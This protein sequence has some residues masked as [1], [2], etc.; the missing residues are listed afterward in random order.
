M[1]KAYDVQKQLVQNFKEC[2]SNTKQRNS[3]GINGKSDVINNVIALFTEKEMVYNGFKIGI[4]PLPS[5]QIAVAL[6]KSISSEHSSNLNEYNSL[7]EKTSGIGFK[8]LTPKKMLQRLPIALAQVQAGNTC[9]NF[10]NEI[11]QK[12]Y[13]LYQAKKFTKKV[14]NNQFNEFNK[15]IVQNGYYID[16]F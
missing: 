5:R 4:F 15:C 10:L 9:E 3:N 7:Q 16:E 14:Y 1:Y 2:N 6:Q 11:R 12:I 13:S 8:L